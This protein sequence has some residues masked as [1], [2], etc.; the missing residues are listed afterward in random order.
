MPRLSRKAFERAVRKAM[1]RIPAELAACIEDV[2]VLVEEEPSGE[3][4]DEL[5]VPEGET[6]FGAYFGTPVGEKSFFD[7]PFEPDR[8]VIYRR[9][10]QEYCLTVDELIEEIEVTVVHEIAHHFGIDE[11]TLA[12]YGYE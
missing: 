8:I 11:E 2:A 1:N 10:L 3:V 9:P 7:V 12:R 6:V 4:L 5:G